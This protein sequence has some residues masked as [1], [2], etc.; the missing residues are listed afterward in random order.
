VVARHP[1]ESLS[2]LNPT[3]EGLSQKGTESLSVIME[4]KYTVR[5]GNG[6]PQRIKQD[7]SVESTGTPNR[8]PLPFGLLEIG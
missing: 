2:V 4:Q 1:T 8:G 6:K 3:E 5:T 7:G